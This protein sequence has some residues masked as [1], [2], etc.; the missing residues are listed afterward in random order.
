MTSN[1][2]WIV[3]GAELVMRRELDAKL[4][5]MSLDELRVVDAIVTKYCTA[6]V[7]YGPLDLE[8]DKRDFRE[9]ARQ[10]GI[11]LLFYLVCEELRRG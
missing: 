9:E 2:K 7:A 6:R 1:V 3:D 5:T 4:A 11:D 8:T 10:E